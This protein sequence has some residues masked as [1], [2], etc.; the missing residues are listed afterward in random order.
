M[1]V[2]MARDKR[3]SFGERLRC[4]CVA[5]GLSQEALVERAELSAQATRALETGK[6]H[7]GYPQPVAALTEALGHTERALPAPATAP[8]SAARDD[9]RST[10]RT[11]SVGA[12]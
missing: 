9:R 5:A 8:A 11:H 3:S 12:G 4:L 6:L 7:P 10:G 1:R 2:S